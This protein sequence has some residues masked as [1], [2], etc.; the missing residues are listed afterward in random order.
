MNEWQRGPAS[1]ADESGATGGMDNQR[2]LAMESIRSAERFVSMT[3]HGG[4]LR[5]LIGIT[6][7]SDD[8]AESAR[9]LLVRA[10]EGL[11]VAAEDIGEFVV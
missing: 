3:E 9:E 2:E 4:D 10:A 6:L 1:G 11:M 5:M 8:D 7:A